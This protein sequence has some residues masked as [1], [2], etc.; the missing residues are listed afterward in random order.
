[1][2]YGGIG[3][4]RRLASKLGLVREIDARVDVLKR[5]LRAG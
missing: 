3:V 1:M 4:M 2:N 5:H